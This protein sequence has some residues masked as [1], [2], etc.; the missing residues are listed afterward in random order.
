MLITRGYESRD[1]DAK[2]P[3]HWGNWTAG[4]KA[5]LVRDMMAMANSDRPGWILLGIAEGEAGEWLYEGLSAPQSASFDPSDIGKKVKR[6]ADPEVKFSVHRVKVRGKLYVAIRVEPFQTMPHICRA[7]SG[8]VVE[9]GAIYVRNEA[10]ETSKITT[11]EQ[12]R[13]LI[14]RATQAH[15][16]SI[17][18]RI[19]EL[20]TQS[21]RLAPSAVAP[22]PETQWA[23]QIEAARREAGKI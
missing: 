9:E 14:E 16:D 18:G 7:S 12:T 6:L 1:L 13:S 8:T 23:G 5:E 11:A 22:E 4:E 19:A 3:G 21:G 2:A 17:V 20:I 15:A 10:C